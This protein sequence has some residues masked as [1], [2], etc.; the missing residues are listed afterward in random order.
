[1]SVPNKSLDKNKRYVGVKAN[2]FVNKSRANETNRSAP[3]PQGWA[4]LGKINSRRVP[5]PANLPS[6]KSEIGVNSPTFDPTVTTN[7]GW[8]S[9]DN[10][11]PINPII[12]PT[13]QQLDSL[14]V[15]SPP[16]LSQPQPLMDIDKPRI[17]PTW[18]TV[19]SGTNPNEKIPSL[20]PLNDFPRLAT[21]PDRKHQPESITN[22]QNP[23]FRP[24]NLSTWKEGGSSRV[25]DMSQ[26]IPNNPGANLYQQSMSNP[27]MRMYPPQMWTY[28]PYTPVSLPMHHH[29]Q[30]Q[31]Q[32]QQHM[33]AMHDYKTPTILRN[34]DIDDLSK[35]TDNT[36]A[37][38]TQE[39]NY[40]EKIRFSDDED[41]SNNNRIEILESK[42]KP[43]RMN[44]QVLQHS[45]L[46]H[47]DE[48]VKQMQDNKNSE[49]INAL[50]IAKQ[51]RD[52]QERNLKY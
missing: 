41:D 9:N 32:Q 8:T 24:A 1:M 31:Q 52:E 22:M 14:S 51:R 38:T 7:H 36:W 37:T 5:P 12:H 21:T 15:N 2:D 35:L 6:L 40:Q 25:H 19:T 18:S 11:P 16:P 47:D 23:S 17:A 27:N 49:L 42:T 33:N 34:K 4:N 44:P 29:H 30:Q 13:Q 43:C 48:H 28:S 3:R 20:L 46:I 45:R 39:V 26:M 50:N 10:Q